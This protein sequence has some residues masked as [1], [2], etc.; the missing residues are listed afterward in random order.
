MSL[1]WVSQRQF[2]RLKVKS[3]NPYWGG[4]ISTMDLLVLITSDQL[5]FT[6]KM[7]SFLHKQAMLRRRS[8]VLSH[9]HQ[10]EFPGKTKLCNFLPSLWS[11]RCSNRIKHFWDYSQTY[12][13][14]QSYQTVALIKGPGPVF[15]PCKPIQPTLMFTSKGITYL[16]EASCRCSTLSLPENIRLGLKSLPG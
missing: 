6:E 8:T 12:K 16:S 4:R 9:P 5:A 7:V 11:Q 3:R 1:F 10:L 14:H 2:K 15:V 13:F